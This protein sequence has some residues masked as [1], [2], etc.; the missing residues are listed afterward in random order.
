MLEGKSFELKALVLFS[1]PKNHKKLL[2]I[3]LFFESQSEKSPT[4][5]SDLINYCLAF[6]FDQR[7]V[8]PPKFSSQI[9]LNT[10]HV[11]NGV[12][13]SSNFFSEKSD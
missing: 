4:N 2:K 9:N 3:L 13:F 11:L 10:K 7:T 8:T 1:E 6:A 5:T 12:T